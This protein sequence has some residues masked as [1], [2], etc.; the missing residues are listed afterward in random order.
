MVKKLLRDNILIKIKPE[1]LKQ[2]KSGLFIPATRKE[3]RVVGEVI[4]TGPGYTDCPVTTKVGETVYV[5]R[6]I[7]EPWR[8]E[9]E[10]YL[11]VRENDITAI[12]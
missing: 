11:I 6:G 10:D 2:L 5:D 8:H 12:C 9:G 7:G 1:E 4:A 3:P